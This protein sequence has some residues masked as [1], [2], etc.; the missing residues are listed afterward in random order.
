MKSQRH[1]TVF[2]ERGNDL[3]EIDRRIAPLMA[4][5]WARGFSTEFSCEETMRE[6]VIPCVQIG[7]SSPEELERFLELMVHSTRDI[8]RRMPEISGHAEL[9]SKTHDEVMLSAMAHHIRSFSGGFR[10]CAWQARLTGWK[11]TKGGKGFNASLT[12]PTAQLSAVE[13]VLGI[14]PKEK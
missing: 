5:L 11:M 1:D 3:I 13:S 4:N 10:D 14:K 9:S 2:V 7:F 6:G 8:I 12:F